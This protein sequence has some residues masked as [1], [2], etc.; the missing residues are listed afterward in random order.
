MIISPNLLFADRVFDEDGGNG[1]DAIDGDDLDLFLGVDDEG[2]FAR[3]RGVSTAVL[4]VSS[5]ELVS[6][7]W[8]SASL[9][10]I[11]S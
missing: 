7:S 5:S 11:A 10:T 9:L 4:S 8:S 6:M 2:C 3:F 1:E